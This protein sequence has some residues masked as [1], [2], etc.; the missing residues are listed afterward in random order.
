MG[1]RSGCS[2][3]SRISK[4]GRLNLA[5]SS[6]MSESTGVR[7]FE[8]ST[9]IWLAGYKI[10]VMIVYSSGM[11]DI[12]LEPSS[13]IRALHCIYFVHLAFLM[14]NSCRHG[15]KCTDRLMTSIVKQSIKHSSKAWHMRVGILR[16][17]F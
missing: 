17:G 13:E 14:Y 7:L 15:S 8:I 6:A 9:C 5:R 1:A 2:N 4:G 3:P 10:F 16:D 11:I 12:G